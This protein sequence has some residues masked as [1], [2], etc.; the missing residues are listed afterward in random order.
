MTNGK[1]VT[2]YVL[3]FFMIGSGFLVVEGSR[4]IIKA[5]FWFILFVIM[6]IYSHE[7]GVVWGFPVMF[8]SYVHLYIIIRRKCVSNSPE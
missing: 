4:G 6:R 1:K 2:A 5:A 8:I 3:N 7:I